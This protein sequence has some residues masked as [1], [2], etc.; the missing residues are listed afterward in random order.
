MSLGRDTIFI[1]SLLLVSHCIL[2]SWKSTHG[3]DSDLLKRDESKCDNVRLQVDQCAFVLEHCADATPG[4][5]NY[6]QWYYCSST[7]PIVFILMCFWL[8]FL[9]GFVGIAASDFFCPNLQTIASVLHL[10]E[11][12]T[13]VTFLAFGNGSP[14]LFSTFS[15][16]QSDLGSLA[17]GELIG[18]ASFIVS[19]V[20][21]SM[22]AIKPFRAKKFS[23]IRDVSFF[24]CAIVLV[25]IIVSDGLIHMYEAIILILFYIVYVLVVV[26]GNYYMK[27][28]S[29][30][31]NLVERAR[32]EYE[33][34]N[35]DV[36][37]LIRGN[38]LHDASDTYNAN[39]MELY[40]EGFE[41][42]GYQDPV[43]SRNGIH[44]KL[45]IRTSLF[46]AIEFQDVVQSL[47]N[48]T[49]NFHYQPH[50]PSSIPTQFERYADEISLHR[51]ESRAGHQDTST[52][53]NRSTR[54]LQKCFNTTSVYQIKRDINICLF[55]SL[56]DFYQKPI[57]SKI[58]SALS[59]P[60]TFLLATTLP[61]VK[62]SA[63]TPR[64][65]ELNDN[66]VDMLRDY[67]EDEIERTDSIRGSWNKWLTAIQL[68]GAPALISFVLLSQSL[69]SA[70]IILP[71]LLGTG[72]ILS[73]TFWLTTSHARQ[74]RLYWMMCFLGFGVAIVW[75]FLI[76]NEVVSVLQAIGMALG[77]SEAILGLT[78]FA[79]GNSLGDF[80]ANVTMAKLG[81]PL[82]A[83]S[84]CFG[85]PMLSKIITFADFQ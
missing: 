20:A 4:L 76:A 36:D 52:T 23:F 48:T 85:G 32:L 80:V 65:I 28:R 57:F 79:L 82:M 3:I 56:I 35:R 8:L 9:F 55:P 34:N 17:L 31:L 26:G 29:N 72:L 41:T 24:A 64:G 5:I 37:N 21:G 50:Q 39:E 70:V 73:I 81:Y 16:M 13:G 62:E 77:A 78:I 59:V 22:C 74:P 61:V 49:I 43:H 63:I 54:L 14:D 30:Y 67:R 19:V 38:F 45:R 40:D 60:A 46:S 10:S 12:L 18:A 1:I 2:Y 53:V 25:M 83:I 69:V 44:P 15:A 58:T 84:A 7:K 51:A 75:I 47:K 27:R 66:T 68:M 71:I 42:E 33:E 6:I 11:S